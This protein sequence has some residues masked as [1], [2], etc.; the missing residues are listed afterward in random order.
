MNVLA[1]TGILLRLFE[2]KAPFNLN[3]VQAVTSIHKRGDAIVMGAQNCAEFWNICT[4]PRRRGVDLT[5]KETTRR[6][7]IMEAVFQVLPEPNPV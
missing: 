3:I 2:P 4:R 1:D 7:S 5:V 6:L